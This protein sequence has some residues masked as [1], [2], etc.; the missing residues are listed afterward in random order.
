MLT[1]DLYHLLLG[2]SLTAGLAAS[3][4]SYLA[5]FARTFSISSDFSPSHLEFAQTVTSDVIGGIGYFYGS[6]RVDRKSNREWD[7]ISN[8]DHPEWTESRELFTATPSRSFFPR[9][10]Y[11]YPVISLKLLFDQ[12][13]IRF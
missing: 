8:G 2:P 7:E 5:R 11:W 9:G 10:F 3:S 13:L 6:S 4:A 12:E 1:Y